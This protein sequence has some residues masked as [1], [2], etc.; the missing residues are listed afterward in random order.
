[1]FLE[2]AR[3]SNEDAHH[4]LSQKIK[5]R[6]APLKWFPVVCVVSWLIQSIV[7]THEAVDRKN[8]VNTYG[9]SKHSVSFL[10]FALTRGSFLQA[11]SN[12]VTYGILPGVRLQW[13]LFFESWTCMSFICMPPEWRNKPSSGHT[14]ITEQVDICDEDPSISSLVELRLTGEQAYCSDDPGSLSIATVNLQHGMC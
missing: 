2:A 8:F 1:M 10:I 14:A 4:T 13:G 3:T 5:D 9:N 6:I 7:R 12:A 11:I